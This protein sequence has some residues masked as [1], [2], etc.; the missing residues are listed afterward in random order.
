[1]LVKSGISRYTYAMK[2][3][4]GLVLALAL[5]AGR[6]ILLAEPGNDKDWPPKTP[7]WKFKPSNPPKDNPPSNPPQKDPPKKDPPKKDPPKKDPPKKGSEP[8]K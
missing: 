3:L 6:G 5:F 4:I 1:M 8:A 7:G 2:K